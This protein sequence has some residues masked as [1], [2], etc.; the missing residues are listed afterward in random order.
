[1]TF[2]GL[3]W[4]YKPANKTNFNVLAVPLILLQINMYM[5]V[6]LY[7]HICMHGNNGNIY[8]R[9]LTQI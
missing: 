8:F 6:R 5:C 1:M 9:S 7:V 3:P 4:V 2:S